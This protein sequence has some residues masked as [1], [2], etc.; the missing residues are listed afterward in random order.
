VV[1]L[2]ILP[3]VGPA[4][5]AILGNYFFDQ[6][7]PY[8]VVTLIVFTTFLVLSKSWSGKYMKTPVILSVIVFLYATLQLVV[9]QDF[10]VTHRPLLFWI[11]FVVL[12]S[13]ICIAVIKAMR[14]E[15]NK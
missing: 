14:G 15:L 12:V 11:I 8:A 5:Y 13:V 7:V 9:V 6:R 10:L 1:N 4:V 3:F 2:P